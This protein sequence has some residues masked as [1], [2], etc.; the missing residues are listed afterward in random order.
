MASTHP[1]TQEP[2]HVGGMPFDLAASQAGKRKS[3]APEILVGLFLVAVF[4]LAGAWFY[5]TSTQTTSYLAL[6]N[7]LERGQTVTAD[8]LSTIDLSTDQNILGMAATRY[9]EVLGKIAATDLQAS[10]LVNPAQFVDAEQIP[11][12]FG[13]IGFDLDLGEHP[14]FALQTGSVVRIMV[15]Q[16][17]DASDPRT[18]T[19]R[20]AVPRAVVVDSVGVDSERRF[21]SILV[22]DEEANWLVSA[23][24]QGLITLI[25]VS[26]S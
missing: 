8:D 5:S 9:T 1:V 16:G 7:D 24:K 17:G 14:T 13:V 18:G 3:R 19:A 20:V 21:V 26:E 25:Q 11:D 22:E 15:D 23:H 4:A 12:G 2:D 6:R 10:T